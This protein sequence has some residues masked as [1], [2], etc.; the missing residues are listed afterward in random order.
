MAANIR[1]EHIGKGWID[2]FKSDG[3]RQVVDQA[4]ER[5]AH[6]AGEHFAYSGRMGN[7]TYGGFVSSNDVEGALMQARGKTLTKAVH[8]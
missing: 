3:M 5:I 1:I 7:F 4:G 6:E 2:I 8:R